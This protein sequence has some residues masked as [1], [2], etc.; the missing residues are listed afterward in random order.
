MFNMTQSRTRYLFALIMICWNTIV[1]AADAQS[2]DFSYQSIEGKPVNLKDFR[3]KWVLVN[4]WATWCPPCLEEIPELVIFHETHNDKNAVV[5]GID[6]ERVSKEKVKKFVDTYSMPY[7]IVQINPETTTVFGPISGL[8]T[9]FLIDP[10][11]KLVARQVGPVTSET[12]EEYINNFS[13]K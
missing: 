12:I 4:F 7:P 2:I 13:E 6:Y 5:I 8:P 10:K 3:G 11:G 1:F 9:S